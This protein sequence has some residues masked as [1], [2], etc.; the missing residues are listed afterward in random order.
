MAGIFGG[1]DLICNISYDKIFSPPNAFA[2]RLAMNQ[3]LIMRHEAGLA[4]VQNPTDGSFFIE[5]LSDQ[6]GK[7]AMDLFKTIE[8]G[9][10][11]LE[12]LK[13]HTIQKKIKQNAQREQEAFE[14]G[15]KILVGSNRFS[16]ST[17]ELIHTDI[18]KTPTNK[19]K[20][21]QIEPLILRRLSR[22]YERNGGE[23]ESR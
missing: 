5:S 7:K 10:G 21:T 12:Q 6:L 1:A 4:Q 17:E 15:T 9:G 13:K 14:K 20:R 18:R 19:G 22:E 3:L 11:F 23:N 2:D 8:A 16:D